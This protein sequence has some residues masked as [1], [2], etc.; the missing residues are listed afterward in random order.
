MPYLTGFNLPSEVVCFTIKVP[1]DPAFISNLMGAINELTKSFNFEQFGTLTPEQ[2]AERYFQSY[3]EMTETG[4]TCMIGCIV[5]CIQVTP[6]NNILY[7]D[8]GTHLRSE[9]PQLWELL[10]PAIKTPVDFTLPDLDG[11]F[12]QASGANNPLFSIGG[13]NSVTLT[14]NELPTHNHG[15]LQFQN[16]PL[17]EGGGVPNPLAVS[18]PQIPATTQNAGLGQPFD[19]RPQFASLNMGIIAR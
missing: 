14:N 1:D 19:N 11:F 12:I 4:D 9:Y 17:P 5:Y 7:F 15:F 6:P 8:G 2:T 3:T 18:A 10:P 13:S 16:L